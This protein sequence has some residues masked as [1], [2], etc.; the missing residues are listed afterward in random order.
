MY[1]STAKLITMPGPINRHIA[2]FEKN[3]LCY[4]ISVQKKL[5]VSMLLNFEKISLILHFS[6]HFCDF[7][8]NFD[9]FLV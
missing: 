7:I 4:L 9:N 8:F 1:A 3:G 6:C 5:I 2:D